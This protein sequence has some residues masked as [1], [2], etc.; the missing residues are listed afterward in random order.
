MP[1]LVFR[2]NGFGRYWS[3]VRIRRI[4]SLER[5]GLSAH[6]C[7]PD[8]IWACT[9]GTVTYGQHRSARAGGP[10][11]ESNQD[12]AGGMRSEA[13]TTGGTYYEV[14]RV[15]ASDTLVQGDTGRLIVGHRYS[16]R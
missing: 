7:E 1:V 10:R 4:V 6:A 13:R 14:R 11:T 12:T 8:V 3:P 9:I 15:C 2:P 16:L 5:A